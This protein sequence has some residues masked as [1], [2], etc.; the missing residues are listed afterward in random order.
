MTK[1]SLSTAWLVTALTLSGCSARGYARVERPGS[2][3]TPAPNRVW[4]ASPVWDERDFGLPQNAF[5]SEAALVELDHGGACFDVI[6]RS[7]SGA[8]GNWRVALDVDGHEVAQ[9]GWMPYACTADDPCLPRDTTLRALTTDAD[10]LVSARGSRLCFRHV[11]GKSK[12]VRTLTL[13]ATQGGT[14][15][16]FHWRLVPSHAPSPVGYD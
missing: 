12:P 6:V 5:A 11:V 4:V 15:L 3:A 14:T 9:S 2:G 16:D 8:D 7:W 13:S 1:A 10:R